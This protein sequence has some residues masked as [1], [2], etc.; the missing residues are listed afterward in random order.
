MDIF[1]KDIFDAFDDFWD[2]LT[3]T[4]TGSS[5]KTKLSPAQ[6]KAD[7]SAL[8]EFVHNF[9]W[10]EN[11][12]DYQAKQNLQKGIVKL[13]DGETFEGNGLLI[14]E[15]GYFITSYHCVRGV[16]GQMSIELANG[17]TY[18]VTKVCAHNDKDDIAIVK[19]DIPGESK[20]LVYRFTNRYN[21]AQRFAIVSLS[22]RNN[23]LLV[24]GGYI[25]YPKIVELKAGEDRKEVVTNQ[26]QM[27]NDVTNGES[28]GI[29]STLD[30]RIY[31]VVCL[32]A[33]S[34]VKFGACTFWFRALDLINLIVHG[35]K[36]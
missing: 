36:K 15:N 22:R 7:K 9:H 12:T 6:I 18:P 2:S 25:N 24:K 34:S 31:G 23:K 20:A 1:D 27:E 4:L 17:K 26:I 3:S 19:A 35:R 16:K 8:R 10:G 30:Y 33:K 13:T 21:I 11:L 14:T 32:G 28:G 29:V 5:V